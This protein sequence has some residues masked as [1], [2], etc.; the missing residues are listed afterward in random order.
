VQTLLATGASVNCTSDTGK[1]PLHLAAYCGYDD[2]VSVLLDHGARVDVLC[3][4]RIS[5]LYEAVD[6]NKK[7]AAAVLLFRGADVN[8][9]CLR[10]YDETV[11]HAALRR[12]HVAM[13][14][15]L[16]DRGADL[17]IA[18]QYGLDAYRMAVN[19]GLVSLL[20]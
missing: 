8:A 14:R 11:L 15:F 16:I 20:K 17:H 10:G 13:A 4:D 3:K 6:A 12:G 1:T 7:A 9:R 5:P 2:T 19:C 18:D